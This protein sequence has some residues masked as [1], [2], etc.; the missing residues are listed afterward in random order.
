MA[1]STCPNCGAEVPPRARCC[2]ACGSD[3]KTGWSDE[4]YAGGLGLPEEGFD[5]DDFVKREFG[6][7]DVRPRGISWL[8][9]LTALGL[10]L[11]GLWMW[12]GR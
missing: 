8:W 11:A 9:W 10:V 7:R 12:F 1:P 2:P 3:E 4:A 5:Y 6:G